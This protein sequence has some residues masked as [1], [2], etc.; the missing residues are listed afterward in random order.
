M[1]RCLASVFQDA[2]KMGTVDELVDEEIID[3]DD[4]EVINQVAELAS[5]CLAMPGDRRPVMWQVAQELRRLAGLVRQRPDTVGG[6]AAFPELARSFTWT[7][8]SPGYTGSRTTEYFSLEK[9]S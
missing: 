8:D 3:E 5:R 2:M 6:L 1:P 9:K 4:L 7:T